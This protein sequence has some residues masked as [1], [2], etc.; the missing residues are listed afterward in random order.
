[1][2]VLRHLMRVLGGLSVFAIR[3]RRV[4]IALLVL[5]GGTVVAV[6]LAAQVL[7]PVALYPFL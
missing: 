2:L 6:T 1:M 7:G 3:T 5:A 4:G